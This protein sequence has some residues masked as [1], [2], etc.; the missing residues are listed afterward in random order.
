M[1]GRGDIDDVAMLTP[2]SEED[3]DSDNGFRRDQS[4]PG[5]RVLRSDSD[6]V[7]KEGEL[8]KYSSQKVSELN[9]NYRSLFVEYESGAL[10]HDM[11]PKHRKMASTEFKKLNFVDIVMEKAQVRIFIFCFYV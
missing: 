1:S 3:N 6:G 10:S 11:S 7:S 9:A 2:A 4:N 8:G 5:R